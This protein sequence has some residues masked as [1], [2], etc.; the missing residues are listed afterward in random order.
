GEK[1]QVNK[2]RAS[3]E[4]GTAP[5]D[6]DIE[7]NVGCARQHEIGSE[8]KG[9][10]H[11]PV[12]ETAAEAMGRRGDHLTDTHAVTPHELL[13]A[14]IDREGDREKDK[15]NNEEGGVVNAAPNHFAHLLG[16]DS[17]HRVHG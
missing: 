14:I 17:R 7:K 13:S 12:K 11:K 15:P 6:P 16:N 3:G 4:Y 2:R 10:K 1:R 5:F 9:P 8:A